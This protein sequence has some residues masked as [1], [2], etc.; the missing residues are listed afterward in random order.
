MG[1][2]AESSIIEWGIAVPQATIA[3]LNS[4]IRASLDDFVVQDRCKKVGQEIWPPEY[5][6][7]EALAARQKA[8]LA[9]WTPIILESGIKAE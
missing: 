4:A 6:T 9:R 3:K 1:A 7:P 8:E 5:Q 2:G